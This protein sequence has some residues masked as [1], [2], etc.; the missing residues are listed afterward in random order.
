MQ[1]IN[2]EVMHMV[3]TDVRAKLTKFF[4]T[5]RVDSILSLVGT[6]KVDQLILDV[7]EAAGKSTTF[8]VQSMFDIF[9]H[10]Y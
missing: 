5:S 2:N 7:A 4:T 9:L 8:D 1:Q 10:F 3:G 6:G